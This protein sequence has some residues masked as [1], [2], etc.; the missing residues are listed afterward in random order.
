MTMTQG[1]MGINLFHTA[2]YGNIQ[3]NCPQAYAAPGELAP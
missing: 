2:S 3:D 1:T